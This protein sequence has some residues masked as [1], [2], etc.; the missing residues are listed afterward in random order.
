MTQRKKTQFT[1]KQAKDFFDEYSRWPSEDYYPKESRL[2]AQDIAAR[3]AMPSGQA[4]RHQLTEADSTYLYDKGYKQFK[5]GAVRKAEIAEEDAKETRKLKRR[6]EESD[7]KAREKKKRNET[8]RKAER[9]QT[10]RELEF[11]NEEM[12]AAKERMRQLAAIYSPYLDESGQFVYNVTQ[13]T[14]KKSREK[15]NKARKAW[16]EEGEL[17]A[18]LDYLTKER[19]KLRTAKRKHRASKIK[20]DW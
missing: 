13:D 12:A 19:N 5:T 17:A 3:A 7:R 9:Q 8:K 20:I 11:V 10:N 4:P 14:D 18:D 6:K 1:D 16:V 2:I 15:A